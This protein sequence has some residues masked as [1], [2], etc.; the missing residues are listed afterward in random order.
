M[1]RDQN[2]DFAQSILATLDASSD[3]TLA[4][5]ENRTLQLPTESM[6]ASTTSELLL[7]KVHTSPTALLS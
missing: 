4:A 1:A 3:A 5:P 2:E 6:L 7:S